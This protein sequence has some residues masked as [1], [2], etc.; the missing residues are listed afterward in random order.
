VV[1]R[2]VKIPKVPSKSF[3]KTLRDVGADEGAI[4]RATR[5]A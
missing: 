1:S 3:L 4:R 2:A 5:Q